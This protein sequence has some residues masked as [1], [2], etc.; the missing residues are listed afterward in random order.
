MHV[1]KYKVNP[2]K[3]RDKIHDFKTAEEKAKRTKKSN[4]DKHKKNYNEFKCIKYPH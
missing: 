1:R 2:Y 3:E 4:L